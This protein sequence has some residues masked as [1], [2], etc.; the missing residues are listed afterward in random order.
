[1]L[2]AGGYIIVCTQRIQVPVEL[3]V[4]LEFTVTCDYMH[5]VDPLEKH[6]GFA[7]SWLSHCLE[8][9]SI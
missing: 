1:M 6:S 9:L 3:K 4:A 7:A 8:N 2:Y 5:L